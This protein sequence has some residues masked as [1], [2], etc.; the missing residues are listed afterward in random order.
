MAHSLLCTQCWCKEGKKCVYI[1][2]GMLWC[3]EPWRVSAVQN[4]LPPF[5]PVYKFRLLMRNV[6]GFVWFL[7]LIILN[8]DN[9]IWCRCLRCLQ[10]VDYEYKMLKTKLQDLFNVSSTLCIKPTWVLLSN[11]FLNAIFLM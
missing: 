9:V 6:I 4:K 3:S 1:F 5:S 7:K 11:P 8:Y 2:Q 10:Q